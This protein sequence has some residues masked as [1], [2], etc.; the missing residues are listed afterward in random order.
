MWTRIKGF[1]YSTDNAAKETATNTTA[2]AVPEIIIP[3]S[4]P[5]YLKNSLQAL[6]EFPETKTLLEDFFSACKPPIAVTVNPNLDH[7]HSNK[8]DVKDVKTD[9]KG[10]VVK[11]KEVTHRRKD[12]TDPAGNRIIEEKI[13][14]P[15]IEYPAAAATSAAITTT[16]MTAVSTE[17]DSLKEIIENFREQL[18]EILKQYTDR[19]RG[20]TN[21]FLINAVYR[22]LLDLAKFQPKNTEDPTT[23]LDIAPENCVTISS[24]HQFD[25]KALHATHQSNTEAKREQVTLAADGRVVT[26]QHPPK[27]KSLINPITNEPFEAIDLLRILVV[28]RLKFEN[29][30]LEV[31]ASRYALSDAAAYYGQIEAFTCLK[32]KYG[33]TKH[34]Y[35][36][37]PLH[38]AV[39]SGNPAVVEH[40]L[41]TMDSIDPNQI[42]Y[43]SLGLERITPLYLAIR[44]QLKEII[45]VFEKHIKKFPN[46]TSNENSGAFF[47]RILIELVVNNQD[48]QMILELHKIYYNAINYLRNLYLDNPEFIHAIHKVVG[49]GFNWEDI[50]KLHESLKENKKG[51]FAIFEIIA[52]ESIKKSNEKSLTETLKKMISFGFPILASDDDGIPLLYTAIKKQNKKVI[53]IH[54]QEKL[55]PSTYDIRGDALIHVAARRNDSSMIKPLNTDYKISLDEKNSNGDTA[56]HIAAQLGHL[57]FAKDLIEQKVNPT[58]KN[59]KGET[60]SY[61][62]LK[63]KK[64]LIVEALP[65][66]EKDFIEFVDV[67]VM[68]DDEEMIHQLADQN[69]F[70]INFDQQD[71]QGRTCLHRAAILGKSKVVKALIECGADP[72]FTDREG[73]TP[74]ARALANEKREA[75][76][77]ISKKI[78]INTKNTDGFAPIHICAMHNHVKS[79]DLFREHKS[80]DLAAFDAKGLAAIH[81]AAIHNHPEFIKKLCEKRIVRLV[82]Q[83]N[84]TVRD[85]DCNMKTSDGKS[86]AL[87][88]ALEKKN[89]DVVRAYNEL[90]PEWYRKNDDRLHAYMLL[91]IK[92]TDVMDAKFNP[93]LKGTDYLNRLLNQFVRI[94]SEEFRGRPDQYGL[95]CETLGR[96]N[97]WGNKF[98]SIFPEG[99]LHTLAKQNLAAP[100]R[101]LLAISD[102]HGLRASPNW[103]DEKGETLMYRAIQNDASLVIRALADNKITAKTPNE[104]GD[105]LAHVAVK[106]NDINVI[107]KLKAGVETNIVAV[108]ITSLEKDDSKDSAIEKIDWSRKN[109][110]GFTVYDLA[111]IHNRQTMFNL[112]RDEKYFPITAKTFDI[113]LEQWIK[114]IA[115]QKGWEKCLHVLMKMDPAT[116]LNAA[117]E[118]F[119]IENQNKLLE[120]FLK[121]VDSLVVEQRSSIA[122][123]AKKKSLVDPVINK[124]NLLGVI[125]GKE[126]PEIT[127]KRLEIEEKKL[128]VENRKLEIEKKRLKK[129]PGL[130]SAAS[131]TAAS[132]SA[133]AAASASAT[134]EEALPL[135]ALEMIK[136]NYAILYPPPPATT[137]TSA[138][139]VTTSTSIRRDSKR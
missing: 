85:M 105:E 64:S 42:A 136:Q 116:K 28:S 86:T 19:R 54:A 39:L 16:T 114:K 124:K 29:L 58:I 118:K 51:M 55:T 40:V 49:D 10:G 115:T 99:I 18:L 63:H 65:L 131:S 90:D 80:A 56:L 110:D 129:S 21:S 92:N 38:Y 47:T 111:I 57:Q 91:A 17:S 22:V 14:V 5:H 134:S 7:K 82:G 123:L 31:N 27:I 107:K 66:D 53:D 15:Y 132:V 3:S 108:D 77:I 52:G 128:E 117:T 135:T 101:T 84:Q 87:D 50:F 23:H 109:S 33:I 24:G 6:R 95:L 103:E 137:A 98:G 125:F 2:A 104:R 113:A 13:R 102:H 70:Q 106:I 11:F 30:K 138:N 9:D 67:A 119:L 44:F 81:H 68:N 12:P 61:L 120:E 96:R 78:G 45:A 71:A 1:F 25:L 72:R 121:S 62:A 79:I 20:L 59:K 48:A 127:K 133:S 32:V 73:Y 4:L 88:L 60:A 37:G 89:L 69:Y 130:F 100:L 97:I 74:L 36:L 34:E 26:V 126:T 35:Q 83:P 94:I 76:N 93:Q 112:F 8:K 139:T 122:L 43:H 75:V 41:S 46:Y